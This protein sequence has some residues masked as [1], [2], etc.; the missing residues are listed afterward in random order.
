MSWPAASK[1]ALP[2]VKRSPEGGLLSVNGVFNY[3]DGSVAR[4]LVANGKVYTKR[5]GSGS[6]GE[7]VGTNWAPTE[8][9][10]GNARLETFRLDA[11]GFELR[12]SPTKMSYDDFYAEDKILH[13]YYQ[14]CAELLKAATGASTVFAFDHNVRSA[15]GKAGGKTVEGGS[16]VQSPAPL[17]HADYT[18]TSAPRRLEQLAEPPKV[19]DTIGKLTGDAALLSEDVMRAAKRGRY[20]IVNVW[21]NIRDKPVEYLPLA[22]CDASSVSPEDLCVFE[23]QYA[24]RVG[25]NYFAAHS[26]AHRW[27]Y[28]PEMMRAEA[29]LLKTWDSQGTLA[30]GSKSTF[31]LHAAFHDPSS[32]ENA[33]DRESIEVRC[34]CVFDDQAAP[35]DA[36]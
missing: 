10:V 13:Q 23:I 26:P 15:G 33:E 32:P 5:D 7:L 16:A 27:Y 11:Q 2:E 9:A 34:I 19:N 14:E 18:V 12:Q 31:A 36:T 3:Q 17:V 24:D 35:E 22:C 20:A 30:E 25:E 4:T 1:P 28:Y 29:I 21:R 6:D 8:V